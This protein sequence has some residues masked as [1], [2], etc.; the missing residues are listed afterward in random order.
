MQGYESDLSAVLAACPYSCVDASF[1]LSYAVPSTVHQMPLLPYCKRK[2]LTVYLNICVGHF[3]LTIL[4]RPAGFLGAKKQ[5]RCYRAATLFLKCVQGYACVGLW[6]AIFWNLAPEPL[7]CHY[8][9]NF[10]ATQSLVQGS[11]H[12]RMFQVS[13]RA[14]L[15][16]KI[17]SDLVAGPQ[18]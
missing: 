7:P 13:A 8:L 3:L 5:L 14:A 12:A 17:R 16:H 4:H 15:D 11:C 1:Q 9:D 6:H 10:L 18:T 2:K